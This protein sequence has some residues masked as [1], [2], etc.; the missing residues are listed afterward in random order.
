M[1]MGSQ[2]KRKYLLKMTSKVKNLHDVNDIFFLQKITSYEMIPFT[3]LEIT[4]QCHKKTLRSIRAAK[5]YV[6]LHKFQ[7]TFIFI[8]ACCDT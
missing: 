5:V 8:V 1:K 6:S 3:H 7:L 4:D 2:T